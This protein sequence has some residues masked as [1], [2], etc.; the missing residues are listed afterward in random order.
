MQ[1][2]KQKLNTRKLNTGT[3]GQKNI[4][5]KVHGHKHREFVTEKTVQ[6][7]GGAEADQGRDVGPDP[8]GGKGEGD[9]TGAG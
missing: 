9:R 5:M 3:T 7:V 2:R 1:P 6:E 4:E 8:G